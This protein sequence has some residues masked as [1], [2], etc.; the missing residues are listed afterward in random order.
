ME[1]SGFV[2]ARAIRGSQD[3]LVWSASVQLTYLTYLLSWR[4][5]DTHYLRV[6]HLLNTTRSLSLAVML[7]PTVVAYVEAPRPCKKFSTFLWAIRT[8]PWHNKNAKGRYTKPLNLIPKWLWVA[9]YLLVELVDSWPSCPAQ[10]SDTS[11]SQQLSPLTIYAYHYHHLKCWF[12][13][14]GAV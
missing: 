12:I 2:V 4:L 3:H 5:V 6:S 14:I 7:S 1:Q 13:Y 9:S 11:H 8:T 10:T